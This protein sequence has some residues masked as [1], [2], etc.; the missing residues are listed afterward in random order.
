M[1]LFK[2]HGNATSYYLGKANVI[3]DILNKKSINSLNYIV[4]M[5]RLLFNEVYGLKGDRA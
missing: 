2:D 4:K 5:K 1:E 3:L